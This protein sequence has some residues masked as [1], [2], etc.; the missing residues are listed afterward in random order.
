MGGRD[1]L[2]HCTVPEWP[3]KCQSLPTQ[4]ESGTKSG[5]IILP[6]IMPADFFTCSMWTR[7]RRIPVRGSCLVAKRNRPGF[8]IYTYSVVANETGGQFAPYA[9]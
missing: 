8:N 5:M 9:H 4:N 3:W 2:L 1:K 6:T 7:E